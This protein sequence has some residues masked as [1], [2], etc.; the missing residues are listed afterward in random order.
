MFTT[1]TDS[2]ICQRM[3]LF[4]KY[5]DRTGM[6]HKEYQFE[7]VRWCLKNELRDSPVGGFIADEMGL[8]KTIMMIGLMLC[9][10]LPRTLIV[11]PPILID[12]WVLQIYRTTGHRALV[13]HGANKKKITLEMMK[14]A[15]IVITSYGDVAYVKRV[16]KSEVG[17]GGVEKERKGLLFQVRWSRVV[18]DEAHHM[19]NAK[20]VLFERVKKLK[21]GI[22]W[23]V[24]GTPIQNRLKDFHNLCSLLGLG[25]GSG[26]KKSG[27][28]LSLMGD[29]VLKRTKQEVGIPM[30]LLSVDKIMVGW[31]NQKELELSESIHRF[32]PHAIREEKLMAMMFAKQSCIM[33][34]LLEKNLWLLS[35]LGVLENMNDVNLKEGVRCSSKLDKVVEKIIERKGNGCGKIV[36]CHFHKEMDEI[37]RRLFVD[38]GMA[39][40]MFDG[41]VG[42][43]KKRQSILNSGVE[44]LLLQIQTGCEGLNLQENYSE[45]YFVSPHWNPAVEEQAIARCHRIGQRKPVVV[46]RFVM[47]DFIEE[48]KANDDLEKEPSVMLTMDNY[49][50][51]VQ[52]EKKKIHI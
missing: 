51:K 4:G 49:I 21:A 46:E 26:G 45:I 9:N 8:G 20:T 22:C 10:F 28:D 33:S 16:R 34:G 43:V 27:L 3:E 6:E 32:I 5:L 19:R 37:G 39:V 11:L 13:Y 25:L 12:Q 14:R 35:E 2:D 31:K 7:G 41:R 15:I 18:Y 24:S 50:S 17:S 42:G 36:F 1:E 52:D 44:V 40:A 30:P 38:G 48:E 23:L 47:G 29:F